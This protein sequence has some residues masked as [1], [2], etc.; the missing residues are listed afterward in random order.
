[1][2]LTCIVH[3]TPL[4]QSACCDAG[5]LKL[6]YSKDTH[7]AHSPVTFLPLIH[8]L[9]LDPRSPAQVP[10]PYDRHVTSKY[11]L[12]QGLIHLQPVGRQKASS[13]TSKPPSIQPLG[14][15]YLLDN[16]RCSMIYITSRQTECSRLRASPP[17]T[18]TWSPHPAAPCTAA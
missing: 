8:Q 4:I 14:H 3:E 13:L 12:L 9:P 10:L 7:Q 5:T 17:S 15:T 16:V 11:W 1:M 6:H 2:L 18:A